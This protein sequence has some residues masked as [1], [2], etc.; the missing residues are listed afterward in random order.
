V[1][2]VIFYSENWIADYGGRAHWLAGT[3]TPDQRG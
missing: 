1:S 2:F 3:K